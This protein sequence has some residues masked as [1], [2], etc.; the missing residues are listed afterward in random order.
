[1]YKK[2][3]LITIFSL[4]GN[5]GFTQVTMGCVGHGSYNI[6]VYNHS[7]SPTFGPIAEFECAS[8]EYILDCAEAAGFDLPYSGRSGADTSGL[9]RLISGMV[10]H[11]D[12]LFLEPHHEVAGYFLTEVAYACSDIIFICCV[13]GEFLDIYSEEDNVN[14]SSVCFG[15]RVSVLPKTSVQKQAIKYYTKNATG[16]YIELSNRDII[17]VGAIYYDMGNKGN[18]FPLNLSFR[19]CIYA[20]PNLRS[21]IK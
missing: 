20:N 19:G 16:Q 17:P 2:L 18:R 8:D 15:S 21:K 14:L 4:V 9:G 1:M 11:S 12:N 7:R 10:D 5:L 6:T 13:E 3:I